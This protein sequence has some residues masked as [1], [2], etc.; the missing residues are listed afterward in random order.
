MRLFVFWSDWNLLLLLR[1]TPSIRTGL[2]NQQGR[3]IV[4]G[5]IEYRIVIEYRIRYRNRGRATV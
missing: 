1:E 3:S 2:V 4:A 5:I